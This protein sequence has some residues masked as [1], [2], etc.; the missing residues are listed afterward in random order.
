MT[1]RHDTATPAVSRA[2]AY[3]P[4]AKLYTVDELVKRR[5][6][7]L[8]DAPLLGYPAAG[9]DDFVEHSAR[10]VDKYVDAAVVEL[11]KLGL[12]PVVRAIIRAAVYPYS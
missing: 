6:S 3:E 2:A 12:N 7:E 1:I 11:R 9:V 8:G 4:E 5:A 10:A